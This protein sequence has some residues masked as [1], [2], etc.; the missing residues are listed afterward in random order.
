LLLTALVLT[1]CVRKPRPSLIR[2]VSQTESVAIPQPAERNRLPELP[3]TSAPA[4]ATEEYLVGPGD[5]IHLAVVGHNELSGPRRV[6]PDGRITVPLAGTLDLRGLTRAEC[7]GLVRERLAPYF[8]RQPSVSL[9]ITEYVNNKA[10][11]LGR[12]EHPGVVDLTGSGT[13]LQALSQAGGLPVSEFRSFLSK[14][15]ILRG[16]DQILWVDL[17]ELLQGGNV[18]LNIPLQNGDI[19][20]IPDA[21]DA[22]VFVMGEVHTPGAVPIRT[23]MDV[24]QALAQTGGPTEYADLRKIFLVRPEENGGYG[25]PL[26]I[27]LENLIETSDFAENLELQSGDILYVARSGM[28]DVEFVLRS[29][30]PALN[31]LILGAALR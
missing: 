28:G 17:K 26:Q 31:I 7:E 13:L 3:P 29:I 2:A 10:Y 25:A 22:I 6:G 30:Q 12:V 1:G 20:F 23:R 8:T 11:V 27:D 14:C 4:P 18:G 9:D 16:R 24:V 15:A 19:V 21:E 5:A